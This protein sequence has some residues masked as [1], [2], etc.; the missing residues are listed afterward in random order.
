MFLG[1]KTSKSLSNKFIQQK[2]MYISKGHRKNLQL[3]FSKPNASG[4]VCKKLVSVWSSWEN[5]KTPSHHR[6]PPRCA[7]FPPQPDHGPPPTWGRTPSPG[8]H[9]LLTPKALDKVSFPILISPSMFFPKY[10][11]PHIS[12]TP[13]SPSPV[14]SGAQVKSFRAQIKY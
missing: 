9:P 8:L 7:E 11:C 14:T 5:G 10:V 12:L 6:V 3:W 13:P 1:H 2:M 4:K